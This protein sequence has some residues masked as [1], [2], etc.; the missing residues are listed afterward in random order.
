MDAGT[1]GNA[2]GGVVG[3]AGLMF[4]TIFNLSPWWC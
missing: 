1:V 4:G 3:G 2:L